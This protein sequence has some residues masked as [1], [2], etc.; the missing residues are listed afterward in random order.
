VG[1]DFEE[2][3]VKE[4]QRIENLVVGFVEFAGREVVEFVAEIEE[5]VEL[6]GRE[7]CAVEFVVEIEES[8][9]RA[10]DWVVE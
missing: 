7:D 8:V 6:V 3:V 5:F 9:E 10:E 4:K 2:L 1:G